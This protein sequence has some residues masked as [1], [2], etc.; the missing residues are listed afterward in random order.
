[1]KRNDRMRRPLQVL[2]LPGAAFALLAFGTGGNVAL[3][4]PSEVPGSGGTAVVPRLRTVIVGGIAGW[5]IALIALVA[6]LFAAA[7]AVAIDRALAA[8]RRE[9]TTAT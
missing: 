5:Q 6:A 9:P 1:M 4:S 2:V 8:R 7:A 3:A